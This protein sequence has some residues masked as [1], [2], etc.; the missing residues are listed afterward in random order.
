[1]SAPDKHSPEEVTKV[2]VV[3]EKPACVQCDAIKRIGYGPTHNGSGACRNAR[4]G[5]AGSIASGGDV[6]HCTCDGCF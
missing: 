3:K 5:V 1:M 6:E 2:Q 4:H